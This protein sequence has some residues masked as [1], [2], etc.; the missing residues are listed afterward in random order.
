MIEWPWPFAQCKTDR[1][2]SLDSFIS[3]NS[4]IN[5]ASGKLARQHVLSDTKVD[6]NCWWHSALMAMCDRVWTQGWPRNEFI[7]SLVSIIGTL[8]RA[9][10][11]QK[12]LQLMHV[13][14]NKSRS[15]VNDAGHQRL[16]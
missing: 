16:D 14:V 7:D 15:P 11:G 8:I 6:T 13:N 4:S 2:A 5:L 1:L 10:A 12:S 9:K 3:F